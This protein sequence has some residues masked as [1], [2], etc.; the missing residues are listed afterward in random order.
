[1][2]GEAPEDAGVFVLHLALDDAMSK[3]AIIRCWRYRVFQ[4]SRGI[5]RGVRHA[6]WAE[7]FALAENVEV[8]VS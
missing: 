8:F 2:S 1:M 5:E 7:D 4:G 3:A 6:E